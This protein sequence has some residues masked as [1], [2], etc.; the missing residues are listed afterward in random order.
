MLGLAGLGTE[1]SMWYVNKRT[2]HSATDS[3]AYSAAT[4]RYKGALRTQWVTEGKS[5]AGAY[6]FV[7]GANNVTVTVNSPATSG[8]YTADSNSIEVII[9]QQQPQ[10]LSGLFLSGATTVRSRSVALT[11]TP[12]TGCVLALDGASVDDIFN[13]GNVTINLEHCDIY[14]NSPSASALTVVG[15][16]SISANGAY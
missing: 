16:A 12:G 11:G 15:S 4:A 10:V 5:V 2:M 8:N 13:N 6:S 1:V 3:A 9:T 14:D 7:D